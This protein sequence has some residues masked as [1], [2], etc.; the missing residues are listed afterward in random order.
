[1]SMDGIPCLYY[2]TEAGF[3]GGNDPANREPLWLGGYDQD[4]PLF[5]HI[6]ALTRLRRDYIALRRGDFEI[7]WVTDRTGVEEDAGIVA[8]Q[9]SYEEESALVVVNTH[10]TQTSSTSFSGSRMPVEFAPGTELVAVFPP[11]TDFRVP[12]GGDG[13]VSIPVEARSGMVLVPASQVLD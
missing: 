7:R 8:F 5:Q 6:A 9:R 1:M 3:A 11:D 2:G 10:P 4:H 13:T 12:V